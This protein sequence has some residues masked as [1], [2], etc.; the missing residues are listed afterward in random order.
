M[1]SSINSNIMSPGMSRN[2][3]SQSTDDIINISTSN[4]MFFFFIFFK[5]LDKYVYLN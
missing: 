3:S 2:N 4:R 5:Y 1:N